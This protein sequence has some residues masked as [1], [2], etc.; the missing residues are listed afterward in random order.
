MHSN[1][2]AKEAGLGTLANGPVFA[3]SSAPRAME[4]HYAGFFCLTGWARLGTTLAH[5]SVQLCIVAG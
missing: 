5:E 3:G 1:S 4:W 2:M